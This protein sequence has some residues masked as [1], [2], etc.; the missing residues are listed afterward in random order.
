MKQ[1]LKLL[2][3]LE[4]EETVL[5]GSGSQMGSALKVLRGIITKD[6]IRLIDRINK[7][8]YTRSFE[9]L[10]QEFNFEFNYALFQAVL[11]G[12]LPVDITREDDIDKQNN[13]FILTQREGDLTV[14][15][16][17]SFKTRRLENLL[18]ST[19]ENNNTLELKYNEF[20]P[21]N[22]KPFAIRP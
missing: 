19:F 18:A 17:I 10:S 15:N 20:K 2:P 16:K 3:I 6:S 9:Q 21:L 13:N 8:A 14:V 5:S 22:D 1:R 11:V 4:S 7:V 12:E